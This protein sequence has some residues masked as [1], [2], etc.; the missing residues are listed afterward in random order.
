MKLS[1]VQLMFLR[2]NKEAVNERYLKF[3]NLKGEP[4]EFDKDTA[5]EFYALCQ[6]LSWQAKEIKEMADS[7]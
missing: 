3:I 5:E 2:M 6:R 4:A 1:K 7:K